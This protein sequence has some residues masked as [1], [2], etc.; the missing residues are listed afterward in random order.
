METALGEVLNHNALSLHQKEHGISTLWGVDVEVRA[1]KLSTLWIVC[2][3]QAPSWHTVEHL[4]YP[5][6]RPSHS[7]ERRSLF[8]SLLAPCQ[9]EET[10]YANIR[11]QQKALP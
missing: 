7:P 2:G 11:A 3:G 5:S 6:S 10:L 1:P 4:K 8:S 9:N